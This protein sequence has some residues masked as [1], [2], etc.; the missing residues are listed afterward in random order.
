[1]KTSAARLEPLIGGGAA[2]DAAETLHFAES[3]ASVSPFDSQSAA[4]AADSQSADALRG[5]VAQVGDVDHAADDSAVRSMRHGRPSVP[6]SHD[7]ALLLLE[8]EV[9]FALPIQSTSTDGEAAGIDAA[10]LAE[11]VELAILTDQLA[12]HL[13]D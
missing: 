2:G 4:A 10:V 9:G 5:A 11:Q 13:L 1:M 12:D 8:V 7:A 6:E 3:S